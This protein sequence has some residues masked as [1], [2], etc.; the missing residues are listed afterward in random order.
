MHFVGAVRFPLFVCARSG[1]GS[2]FL[3][4]G[5]VSHNCQPP[6]VSSPLDLICLRVQVSAPT[7]LL[8]LPSSFGS[9]SRCCEAHCRG[10]ALVLYESR[11]TTCI[12]F[13]PPESGFH[14]SWSNF[15]SARQTRY[16]VS[17]LP[18]SPSFP[19]VVVRGL[20]LLAFGS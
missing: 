5:F 13:R 9:V 12:S 6:P 4:L 8:G 10:K 17:F 2:W 14:L 11:H 18:P 1:F 20:P 7:I 15:P 19:S 16:Q 3:V